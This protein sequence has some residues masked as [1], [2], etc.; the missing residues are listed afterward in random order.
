MHVLINMIG[1]PNCASQFHFKQCTFY[2]YCFIRDLLQATCGCYV[3][4]SW[5]TCSSNL[6]FLSSFQPGWLIV[7]ASFLSLNLHALAEQL[8]KIDLSRRLFIEANL[9]PPEL[10]CLIFHCDVENYLVT[11]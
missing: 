4:F 6:F 9:L 7:Q 11:L 1:K 8:A 10:V 3:K 5:L 2:C